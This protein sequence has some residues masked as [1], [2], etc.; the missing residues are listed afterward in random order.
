MPGGM[1]CEPRFGRGNGLSDPR[2]ESLM[3][4]CWFIGAEDEV[5]FQGLVVLTHLGRRRMFH[6][7]LLF[8]LLIRFAALRANATFELEVS[9]DDF[10]YLRLNFRMMQKNDLAASGSLFLNPPPHTRT[11]HIN[12]ST[13]IKGW[14]TQSS[15]EK[16]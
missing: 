16:R 14:I 13:Y 15:L 8:G 9:Q 10:D 5:G 7:P 4:G 6:C 12:T 3:F 11:I 2:V 1:G